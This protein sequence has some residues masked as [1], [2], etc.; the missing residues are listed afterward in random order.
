M[1]DVAAGVVVRGERVLVSRRLPDGHLAGYWEFPGGKLEPGES[2]PEALVREIREELDV[3]IDV[4]PRWGVLPVVYDDRTVRL[5]FYFAT[6]REGR[7][8]ALGCA[9]FRW[10]TVAELSSLSFPRADRQLLQTLLD[11]HQRGA[12]ITSARCARNEERT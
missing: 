6:I 11:H 9:E 10:V 1:I 4:G 12:P 5:H 3:T 7:P 8:R 2:P